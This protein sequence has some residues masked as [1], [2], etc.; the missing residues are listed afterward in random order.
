[1]RPMWP[2][3]LIAL[4]AGL[5]AADD[6]PKANNSPE[7][8]VRAGL[9][10][11]KSGRDEDYAKLVHPDE[12]RKFKAA[13]LAAGQSADRAGNG[14]AFLALFGDAA[15]SVAELGK[16]DDAQFYAAF[17]RSPLSLIAQWKK[18]MER[19]QVKIIG[20]V[21]EGDDT[22]HVVFRGTMSDDGLTVAAI[23][24]ASLRKTDRGWRLLLAGE[25]AMAG[26]VKREWGEAATEAA[27]V[28][29]KP[30]KPPEGE[31]E[32]Q[33]WVSKGARI[34]WDPKSGEILRLRFTPTTWI[35]DIPAAKRQD[36]DT[37]TFSEANGVQRV[38]RNPDDPKKIERGIWKVEGDT[39]TVCMGLPGEPRPA[40]FTCP[41]GAKRV[42]FVLKRVKKD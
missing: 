39:L 19:A 41:V 1:M 26:L 11:L 25:D 34:P 4:S 16:L 9:A 24:V 14:K 17:L 38:D 18:L 42:L 6:A 5:V 8:V 33:S 13:M 10:A 29:G 36:N 22:V 30:A 2:M 12:L 31:W 37:A 15:K 7:D 23:H 20:R 27:E 35:T 3:I 28:K 40:D 32:L 21:P